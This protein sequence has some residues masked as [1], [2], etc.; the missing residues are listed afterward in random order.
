LIFLTVSWCFILENKLNMA[1]KVWP[2]AIESKQPPCFQYDAVESGS[3]CN[4]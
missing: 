2:R 1:G 3:R 4:E